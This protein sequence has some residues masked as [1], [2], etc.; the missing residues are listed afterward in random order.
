ME[1]NKSLVVLDNEELI[2]DKKTKLM[3][4]RNKDKCVKLVINKEINPIF[5]NSFK[6]VKELTIDGCSYNEERID[7]I[8]FINELEKLTL[9]NISILGNRTEYGLRK[10]YT[11]TLPNLKVLELPNV[12]K[13]INKDYIK[14]FNNLETIIFNVSTD[15]NLDLSDEY[16]RNALNISSECDLKNIV[17]KTIF[18]EHNINL[19]YKPSLITKL[20]FCSSGSIILNYKNKNVETVVYI[21]NNL[22][23]KNNKLISICDDFIEENTLIVPD[24]ISYI[25]IKNNYSIKEINCIS[26]NPK[27]INLKDICGYKKINE[28]ID[29]SNI[30]KII[31]RD[32]NEMS[33]LKNKEFT[34]S[35][36]GEFKSIYIKNKK[37]YISFSKII[38]EIDELGNIENKKTAIKDEKIIEPNEGIMVGNNKKSNIK[39]YNSKQL[40]YYGCYKKI[41]ELLKSDDKELNDTMNIVEDRLIKELKLND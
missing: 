34:T 1:D 7:K 6:N 12:L 22:I 19:D 23:S 3:N 24:Y 5:L 33:L 11:F 26:I 37:L 13:Y 14:N 35:Q 36:Y 40:E 21:K 25:D 31:I 39:N 30:K 10:D 38:I 29:A 4:V 17:I 9:K 8:K 18:N 15:T 27:K 16:K 2:L 28:Y 20:S 41:L 32:N